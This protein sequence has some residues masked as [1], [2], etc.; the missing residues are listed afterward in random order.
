MATTQWN[1][2]REMEALRRELDRLIGGTVADRRA[3]D[4]FRA[5]FLP[6]RAARSY[7][8][9]N[10]SEDSDNIYVEALAPG[11]NPDNLDIS[12]IRNTLRIS[13]EKQAL[14]DDIKPEAFHRNERSAG[15]FTRAIEL[16]TEVDGDKVTAD[17]RDGVLHVKLP[18]AEAA[19]PKQI[20]VNVS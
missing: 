2:F 4:P 1:P 17:Y 11:M 9:I 18:K 13:G 8:L 14:S 12:V 7:P 5:A 19:K 3:G 16:P 10:L 6:G 20:N 15:R